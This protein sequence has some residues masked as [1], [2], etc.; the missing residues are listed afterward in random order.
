[1]ATQGKRVE[2][3]KSAIT[4]DKIYKSDYQKPGTL[5]AQLRQVMT[6]KSYY[7]SKQVTSDLGANLFEAGD[8][9]F[10]E[11][12]FT[13]VENRIAWIDVPETYTEEQVKSKLLEANQKGACLYKI[14]SNKP[15]VT[16]HQQYSISV[17]NKTMDDFANTQVV[18]YSEGSDKAGQIIL[19]ENNKPQYR[20]IFLWNTPMHDQDIR[21]SD[22]NDVY[23]SAEIKAELEGASVM[24]G[25]TI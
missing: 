10:E 25:Q 13:S 14:L 15:I 5:T 18:R 4:L 2:T 3:S 19:D 24:Q 7:P 20:K 6:T 8:F 1:M 17:G 22:P 21:N 11:K 16:N 23:M 9:G 12:D